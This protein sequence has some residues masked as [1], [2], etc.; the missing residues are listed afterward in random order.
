MADLKY[1]G[2]LNHPFHDLQAA[3]VSS[4]LV[5][6]SMLSELIPDPDLF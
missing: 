5:L 3:Q 4:K 6:S 2:L 1:G